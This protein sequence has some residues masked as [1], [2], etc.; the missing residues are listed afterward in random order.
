MPLAATFD[1]V[2]RL[3]AITHGRDEAPVTPGGYD[4]V[5]DGIAAALLEA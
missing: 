2:P 1:Y 3:R 5:P 4:V